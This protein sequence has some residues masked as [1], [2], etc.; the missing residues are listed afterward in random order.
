[1]PRRTPAR[2]IC[3]CGCSASFAWQAT[4]ALLGGAG[5]QG[6]GG[7]L[8]RHVHADR[9]LGRR[10]ADAIGGIAERRADQDPQAARESRSLAERAGLARRPVPAPLWGANEAFGREL[11]ILSSVLWGHALEVRSRLRGFN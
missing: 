4:P 6:L 8:L 9:D 10:P 3:S 5:S 11:L 2:D 1:M 7:A